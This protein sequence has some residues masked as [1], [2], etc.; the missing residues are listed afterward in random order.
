MA[1]TEKQ[2]PSEQSVPAAGTYLEIHH[3]FSLLK[4]NRTG[5]LS[6]VHLLFL[7]VFLKDITATTGHTLT[8]TLHVNNSG[9]SYSRY[10]P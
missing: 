6:Q 9:I 7:S 2:T 8:A 10:N 3:F 4:I 5:I 1:D